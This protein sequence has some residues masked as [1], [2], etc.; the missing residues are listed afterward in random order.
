MIGLI[1]CNNFYV[2]C[3]RAF[4]PDLDGV[5][6]GVLSNNDGCVIARSNELKAL[7]VEMGTP[8]FELKQLLRQRRIVLLSS[9]YE[10]YGDMSSR[11][12]RVLEE[13]SAGVEPYSIDEMFV[14]F[15]GFAPEQM[16]DHAQELFTKVRRFT[17]IPVSV[18]IAPTRT[19]AKL[20]NRMAK[21]VPLYGGVCV[22]RPGTEECE[23]L[24]KQ[25]AIGDVWG[26]GRRLVERL[27]LLGLH[28]ARDLAQADAKQIR[29]RFSVTLE[30]TCL[31]LKGIPC[32]EMNDPGDARQRIMT[33]R[34][35]GRLTDDRQ[36]IHQAIRQF[37][38]RSAEK[39][40]AQDSLTRAVYVFLKTN[41]HR[42]DLPQ[43]SPSAIVE[44]P[45]PS[46]DSRAI[47]HAASQAL[48]AIYR[49]RYR[50]MKAGVMLVDL[51][52]ANREQ[53][54][55]LDT[56][57]SQ[58]ESA[59]SEQ[60]MSALDQLNQRMGKGTVTFGRADAGA[61]WHLRC[62]NRTPRWTTRWDELPVVRPGRLRR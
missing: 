54:S 60:L 44:L 9:N 38:Q 53:L 59:R 46:D 32:I 5:P 21:K 51:I 28:S 12:Q 29:R 37:A 1:D 22:M 4:R 33:S 2:S 19:L 34:S 27:A 48:D 35:F 49:P 36:Q 41:R 50:F 15:D 45:S 43:Y 62:A 40:R 13:F 11:V 18:G 16:H 30:R 57:Q 47:L 3:E 14:R 56:P 58:A 52:D 20:A 42:P 61:A 17:H 55:L 6:V 7:G 31:E 26:V 24:L 25:V 8:A 23:A 10:L 39:L